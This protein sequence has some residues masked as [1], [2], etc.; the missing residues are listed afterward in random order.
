MIL[1]N[2]HTPLCVGITPRFNKGCLL[3]KTAHTTKHTAS[4]ANQ[5]VTA[6]DQRI[7]A[8]LK[9]L[10]KARKMSLAELA[11]KANVSASMLSQTERGLANPSIKIIQRVRQALDVSLTALLED[12]AD[13]RSSHPPHP[14]V[15]HSNA[16]MQ[17]YVRRS[18]DRPFLQSDATGMRKEL[19][20]PHGTHEL[21]FMI[22]ELMPNSSSHDVLIG[23]GE[24][25]GIVLEGQM[26]L[27]I[28]GA[29]TTLYVGDSFQFDSTLP[30]RIFNTATHALKLLWIM[31]TKAPLIRF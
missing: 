11:T 9:A 1:K 4:G 8:R 14:D 22:I 10:R 2:L 28:D 18:N 25:A 17:N 29:S 23:P 15:V 16:D 20:S 30:H 3:K 6:T 27:E 31:N 21:E 13:L 5:S 19:L 26:I 24:K 12:T 7:G